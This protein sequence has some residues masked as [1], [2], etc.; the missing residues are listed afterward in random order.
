MGKWTKQDLLKLDARFAEDGVHMH[1]RPFRAAMEILGSDF[2]YGVIGNSE[3]ERIMTAY[4]E[5]VPEVNSSWPG[6]GIGLAVSVDRIRKLIMPVVFGTVSIEPWEAG[7]SSRDEWLQW[8]RGDRTIAAEAS[9]AF[10]DLHDLSLG[11]NA[12]QSGDG[13]ALRL[14]GMARSNLEDVANT[15]PSTFSVD[16]V[17]QPICLV[18]ELAMKAALVW[19]GADPKS[20]KGPKGHDLIGLAGQLAKGKPHPDDLLIQGVVS[21]LPPY[22]VSRYN[23]AGLTRLQVVRLALGVQFI[24][25]STT[26]RISG[27][28]LAARMAIGEWPGARQPL[29]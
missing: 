26:R 23:P 12:L 25:A 22:V 16:S 17:I 4:A 15:L 14:W 27:V 5:L 19:E 20:F 3:T 21:K 10:A 9:Y 18:A 2:L 28:D 1:Q 24:A 6:A 7:F 29:A 13:D 8:C 11:L